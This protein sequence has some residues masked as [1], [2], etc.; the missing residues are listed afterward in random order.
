MV[1][2]SHRENALRVGAAAMNSKQASAINC[3]G[4]S[5]LNPTKGSIIA[6]AY[7]QNFNFTVFTNGGDSASGGPCGRTFDR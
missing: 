3:W 1:F 2:A 4:V 7:P 5:N 6:T